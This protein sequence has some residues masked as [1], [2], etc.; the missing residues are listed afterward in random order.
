M[1]P[2]KKSEKKHRKPIVW[3]IL[4]L[5]VITSSIFLLVNR[6]GAGNQVLSHIKLPK[7]TATASPQQTATDTLTPTATPLFFENFVDNKKGWF[8]GD[9]AGYI[10]TISN[11]QLTLSGTN[12]KILTESLPSTNSFTDFVFSTTFTILKADAHDS[13]GVY[14]RGDSNLDHDYRID[15]SGNTTYTVSKE[16]LD[17]A[18]MDTRAT[19]IGPLTTPDLLPIG[20]QN[21]LTVTM[22]GST[23]EIILNGHLVNT[24][25]D[26]DYTHGQIALFVENGTTSDAVTA[27][28]SSIVVQP[29]PTPGPGTATATATS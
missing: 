13:V 15:I 5:L 9:S 18:N 4:S 1:E 11:G 23:M 12:H 2:T 28:F 24:I 3:V 16:S 27:T 6:L 19:L 10:R 22:S 14:L 20:H 29:L 26:A 8:V 25:I 7:Q 17:D 21:T